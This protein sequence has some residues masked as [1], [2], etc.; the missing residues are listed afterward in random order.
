MGRVGWVAGSVELVGAIVKAHSSLSYCA[1]TPL[2]LGAARA[3]EMADIGVVNFVDNAK[4][5][6]EALVRIGCKPC[7]AQGGY[8]LVADCA[9]ARDTDFAMML[10]ERAKVVAT[11]MTVFYAAE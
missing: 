9:P 4:N 6:A 5:L 10:A 3:L 1:P 7:R 2:Q 11:P 8:F